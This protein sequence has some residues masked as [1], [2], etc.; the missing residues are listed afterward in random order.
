MICRR[1]KTH[2]SPPYKCINLIFVSCILSSFITFAEKFHTKK[3][4]VNDFIEFSFRRHSYT[5]YQLRM[6][7]EKRKDLLLGKL[8]MFSHLA[9]DDPVAYDIP[10]AFIQFLLS[11][12]RSDVVKSERRYFLG[13]SD[14]FKILQFRRNATSDK[15]A[16]VVTSHPLLVLQQNLNRVQARSELSDDAKGQIGEMEFNVKKLIDILDAGLTLTSTTTATAA[17]TNANKESLQNESP[18]NAGEPPY[19]TSENIVAQYSMRTIYTMAPTDFKVADYPEQLTVTYWSTT[20]FDEFEGPPLTETVPCDFLE[21]VKAY[22]PA[23]T[24][25]P[26]DCKRLLHLSASPQTNRE[27][28]SAVSATDDFF[29]YHPLISAYYIEN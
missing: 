16:K 10:H 8:R 3:L 18:N 28:T 23:D 7:L 26:N 13:D 11:L 27:R 24:N 21:I 4:M 12:V 19:P 15:D 9:D 17:T 14:L 6:L 25:L 1:K 22:L 2:S 29:R 20:R 5:T